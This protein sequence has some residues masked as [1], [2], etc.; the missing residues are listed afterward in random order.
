MIRSGPLALALLLLPVLSLQAQAGTPDP[1]GVR[2]VAAAD[3]VFIEQLTCME[4]REALRAGKT[5]AII[6]TGGEQNRPYLVTGN[7]N[8]IISVTAEAIAREMG[9]ALVAPIVPFVP[10]GNI[11]PPSGHMMYPGT[12]SVRGETFQALLIE[13][14]TCEP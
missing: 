8:V 10:E 9:N 11:D 6:A 14:G 1:N 5:T 4:V 2:P 12:I 13:K 7:H 3:E